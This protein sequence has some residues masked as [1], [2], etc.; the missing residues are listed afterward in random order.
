M[1]DDQ[2]EQN[3]KASRRKTIGGRMDVCFKKT[4]INE[5]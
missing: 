1:M 4:V 2:N 5:E 3:T